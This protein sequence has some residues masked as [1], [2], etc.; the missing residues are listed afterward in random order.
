MLEPPQCFLQKPLLRHTPHI[1]LT[2]INTPLYSKIYSRRGS[3]LS[4]IGCS[5]TDIMFGGNGG[6]NLNKF[7][8][9]RKS[10]VIGRN[11][12]IDRPHFSTCR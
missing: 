11:L 8:D 3:P 9:C 7:F 12:R 10:I 1:V 5:L 4:N 2:T 6:A